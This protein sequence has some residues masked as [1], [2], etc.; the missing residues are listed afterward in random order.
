MRCGGTYNRWDQS[1]A[2]SNWY[3]CGTH[4]L[5]TRLST[6]DSVEVVV[7]DT[8]SSRLTVDLSEAGF[9]QIGSLSEG[10]INVAITVL[11]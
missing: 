8:G 2:A 3:S 5:V 6:G 9:Q 7:R 4:L 10:S 11:R 1:I